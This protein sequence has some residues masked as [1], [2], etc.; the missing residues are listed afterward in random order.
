MPLAIGL[1]GGIG[2][3]KTRVADLFREFGATIIDTDEIA[4]GLTTTRGAATSA[5]AREFGPDYLAADG[6]LDRDR[7]REA[8]FSDPAARRKLEGILHPRIR[9][10]VGAALAAATTPYA[11]VVVPLLIETGAY[12][13]TVQRIAVV[14]CS[15]ELQ[16][17]RVMQRSGLTPEQ[18][19]AIMAT[20]ANR[21]ERLARADDVI[22]NEG[23]VDVLR[24]QVLGLHGK[25]LG[26]A[27]KA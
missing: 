21:P 2:S 27:A 25:Y 6:A 17:A 13:D 18:V 9:D 24:A 5:I 19:R 22:S 8:V 7:M 4:R 1:T 20:Q 10:A 26:L 11:V 3:G 14:D 15:E 23:D 12:R 16:V